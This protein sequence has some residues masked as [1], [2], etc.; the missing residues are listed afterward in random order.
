MLG[1]VLYILCGKLQNGL[2]DATAHQEAIES[3]RDQ[4]SAILPPPNGEVALVMRAEEIRSG[5]GCSRS[6][7]GLYIAL[8]EALTSTGPVELLTFDT[9]IVNQAARNAPTVTVNLLST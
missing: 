3:L 6:S 2:L 9:G 7:D 1:E 4:M 5:Y 8:A